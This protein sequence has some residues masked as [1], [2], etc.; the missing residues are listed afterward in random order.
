MICV[1]DFALAQ[2]LE[3][4]KACSGLLK[5]ADSML[6]PRSAMIYP[7]YTGGVAHW[8]I[9][10]DG[11]PATTGKHGTFAG[12]LSEF[13]CWLSASKA[14]NADNDV[15]KYAA[16]SD[17]AL[18]LEALFQAPEIDKILWME[19]ERREIAVGLKRFLGDG[20]G[21]GVAR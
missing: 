5:K 18:M 13:G 4:I 1:H 7:P 2:Q 15:L 11:A 3:E 12:A 10:V 8:R 17:E 6:G 21:I 14:I 19:A 9:E 20:R 16:Y